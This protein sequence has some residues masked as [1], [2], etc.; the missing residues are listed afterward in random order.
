MRSAGALV[1]GFVLVTSA[2]VLAKGPNPSPAGTRIE[3]AITAIDPVAQ[4]IVVADVTVQATADT[5]I[6][7]KPCGGGEAIPI[8]FEDLALGQTVRASGL[9]DGDVLV[10]KKIMVKYGGE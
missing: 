3:G 10:A 9:M 4:Q 1:L 2:L 7:L 8:S 5:A 6:L